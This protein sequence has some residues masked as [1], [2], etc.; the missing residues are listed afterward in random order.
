MVGP[1]A[2]QASRNDA[3]ALNAE[4]PIE[5]DGDQMSEIQF[6]DGAKLLC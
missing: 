2:D 4:I 3:C 5:Q 1:L 6:T